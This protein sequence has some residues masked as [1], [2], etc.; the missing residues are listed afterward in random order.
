MNQS[1]QSHCL[2]I[3]D[4]LINDELS[5]IFVEPIDPQSEEYSEYISI[6]KNPQFFRTIKNKLKEKH[7]LSV[8][9]SFCTILPVCHSLFEPGCSLPSAPQLKLQQDLWDTRDIVISLGWLMETFQWWEVQ[10]PQLPAPHLRSLSGELPGTGGD[11]CCLHS[12]L[13]LSFS[14]TQHTLHKGLHS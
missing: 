4:K 10:R 13:T 14:S 1:H 2:K 12:Q 5:T 8:F 3:I 11:A 6:I 7:C 9:A